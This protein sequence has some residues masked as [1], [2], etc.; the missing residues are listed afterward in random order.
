MS[1]EHQHGMH[2]SQFW[3][4]GSHEDSEDSE[5]SK[6]MSLQFLVKSVCSSC[7]Y[8]EVSE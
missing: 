7:P 2:L 8:V 1:S 4:I 5:V 6:G 3:G